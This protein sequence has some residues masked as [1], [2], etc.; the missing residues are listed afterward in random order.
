MT[1][2]TLLYLCD[3]KRHS[4]AFFEFFIF[5]VFMPFLDFENIEFAPKSSN[6]VSLHQSCRQI[7]TKV[8]K[9]DC[10]SGMYLMP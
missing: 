6:M 9:Q 5:S 4:R 8:C 1:F 10:F 3:G 2:C 7:H